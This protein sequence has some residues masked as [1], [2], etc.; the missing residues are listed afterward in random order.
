MKVDFSIYPSFKLRSDFAEEIGFVDYIRTPISRERFFARAQARGI[1]D[2]KQLESDYA[3]HLVLRPQMPI[4][5]FYGYYVF[6]NAG[7]SVLSPIV[8][9]GIN[10]LTV[11][12]DGLFRDMVLRANAA[13]GLPVDIPQTPISVPLSGKPS[14]DA[15]FPTQ[16]VYHDSHASK[17]WIL[18]WTLLENRVID[19]TMSPAAK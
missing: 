13:I 6:Q 15:R 4:G 16:F 10:R 12:Y 14:G 18:P 2:P 3:D 19:W 7:S 11:A 9:D 1:T 8:T 17:A 5:R